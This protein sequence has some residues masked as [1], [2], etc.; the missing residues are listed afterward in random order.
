MRTIVITML[1]FCSFYVNAQENQ[2]ENFKVVKEKL[3]GTNRYGYTRWIVPCNFEQLFDSLKQEYSGKPFRFSDDV[4]VEDSLGIW[5]K[6]S[7]KVYFKENADKSIQKQW[8]KMIP[9]SLQKRLIKLEKNHSNHYEPFRVLAL[10]TNRGDVLAVYFELDNLLLDLMR[11]DELLSIS[12]EMKKYRFNPDDF[13]FAQTDRKHLMHVVDSIKRLN[14]DNLSEEQRN[15]ANDL[16]M[17]AA[18]PSISVKYGVITC[19][20][21]QIEQIYECGKT[22]MRTV[23]VTRCRFK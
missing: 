10:V 3:R 9:Q 22:K 8:E 15:E 23:N 12:N 6:E 19:F 11:E 18:N 13:V 4:P 2:F 21:M 20:T 1:V 5:L 7:I 14:I 17:K 16:L